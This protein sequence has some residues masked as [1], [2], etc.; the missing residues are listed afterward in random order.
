MRWRDRG[1]KVRTRTFGSKSAAREYAEA[2]EASKRTGAELADD[3][4]RTVGQVAAMWLEEIER[5][6]RT[7]KTVAGYRTNL[8]VHVLPEWQTWLVG[9]VRTS[10][11]RKWLTKMDRD[12]HGLSVRSNA[13]R[14]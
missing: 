1:N 10:D 6:G 14:C 11:V 13:R 5:S 7:A 3:E 4:G 8:R 12:S 9:A 2:V